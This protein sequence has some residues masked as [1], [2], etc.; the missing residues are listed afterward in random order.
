MVVDISHCAPLV[1]R[2]LFKIRWLELEL[3]WIVV[4]L[5]FARR[6]LVVLLLFRMFE[7]KFEPGGLKAPTPL[8]LV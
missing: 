8:R 6:I 5:A 3:S 2:K 1:A 7:A 4:E